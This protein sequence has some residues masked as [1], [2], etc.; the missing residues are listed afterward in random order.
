MNKLW[1]ALF[2]LIS[3]S[4]R[5]DEICDKRYAFVTSYPIAVN[6]R[7]LLC[8]SEAN[9]DGYIAYDLAK[10]SPSKELRWIAKMWD[11]NYKGESRVPIAKIIDADIAECNSVTRDH[12]AMAMIFRRQLYAQ[13]LFFGTVPASKTLPEFSEKNARSEY[14]ARVKTTCGI[15]FGLEKIDLVVL[16]K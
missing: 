1:I 2:M 7:K 10:M 12:I 8:E 9:R 13:A 11:R 3:G 6:H 4:V 5:A 15:D 14:I 16:D